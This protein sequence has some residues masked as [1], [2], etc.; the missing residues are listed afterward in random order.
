MLKKGIVLLAIGFIIVACSSSDDGGTDD[1]MPMSFDRTAML[2]NWADNIIVPI[3]QDLNTKLTDLVAQKDA[4]ISTPNQSNLDALRSSWYSAYQVW[5]SAEMFNIGRAEEINFAFQMN[6]YPTNVNDIQN[7]IQSQNYDLANVNNNDAVGFP[8]LDYMLYGLSNNDNDILNFYTIDADTSK[9][10]A[11]LS[12]LV[13]QMKALSLDVN[14][15]WSTYRQTFIDN[16]NNTATG[17]INKL[18]NDF[19][20]YYEK[21][22]RANK[23]GIPAGNFSTTPLPDKVEGFYRSDISKA[24]ATEALTAVKDFFNGSS[25]NNSSSGEGLASYLDY[26]NSIKNAEDLSVL[27]NNQFNTAQSK[28]N[29][30]DNSF[31]D[32]I[33]TDNTKMT[34]AYDAL[35]MA[36]VLLKVDMLQALNISVDYVDAD[37]D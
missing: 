11:Y 5:Q 24:L 17:S 30:L 16:S 34:E 15:S 35:Q 21:G 9:Y 3:Y 28:I 8:A 36:V 2:T 19:M 27:I 25:Y 23:I 13:D 12:D 7:N 18:V 32:Q 20:F 22:L 29:T 6:I 4:F 14:S 33:N 31:T 10:L 1:G 26:L 37:G